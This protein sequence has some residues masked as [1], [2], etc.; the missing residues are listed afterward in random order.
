MKK[1]VTLCL[2]ATFLFAVGIQAEEACLDSMLE[3][4]LLLQ[5]AE[6][7][8]ID[9]YDLIEVLEGYREYRSLMDAYTKQRDT[10]ATAL[11]AAIANDDSDS[12]ISGL[13]REIMA[14]DISIIRL[15]QSTMDEAADI[16]RPA[17]VAELYLMVSDFDAVK[18]DLASKL[19]ASQNVGV[20][21][22]T[23]AVCPE[24][25]PCPES[26]AA[27]APAA[28]TPEAILALATDFLDK[29]IAGDLDAAMEGVSENFEHNEY[30]DK[31]ELSDFLE[32]A[33][34]MGYLEDASVDL[35]D[36]EVTFEDGSAI[37]YPLDI[38]GNFGSGTLEFVL[39]LEDDQ[40]MLVGLDAFGI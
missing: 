38:S 18:A 40:W 30:S 39:K 20:V 14:L 31:E 13:T 33:I 32:M 8:G 21:C 12:V 16:M 6:K 24:A 4:V 10:K 19:A 36:T 9:D 11:K 25:A 29:L 3:Q 23:V 35:E 28:N 37:V 17:E 1:L 22:P 26:A 5:F 27:S 7:A 34:D 2:A 15:K